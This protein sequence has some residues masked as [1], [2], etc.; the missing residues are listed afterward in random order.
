MQLLSKVRLVVLLNYLASFDRRWTVGLRHLS[1][2]S[3]LTIWAS[4][5]KEPCLLSLAALG[6]IGLQV[7]FVSNVARL[8]STVALRLN[9][10]G[11]SVYHNVIV[12]AGVS[13][14]T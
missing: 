1:T 8:N 11:T 4:C 14:S 7:L 3:P 5:V 9:A 6:T 12:E 13:D 10:C 2:W